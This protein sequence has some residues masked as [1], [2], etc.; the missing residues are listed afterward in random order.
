VAIINGNDAANLLM[1]SNLP[2]QINGLNGDDTLYGYAGVDTLTGGA[3]SD[4]LFG[5]AGNDVYKFGYGVGNDTIMGDAANISDTVLFGT[6]ITIANLT[7]TPNGS[8]LIVGVKDANGIA[9]DTM[10]IEGWF[11]DANNQIGKFKFANGSIYG[12]RQGDDSPNNIVGATGKDILYGY[13]GNDTLK[14]DA[15]DDV[16]YGGDGDD[17]V[18]GG[19]GLDKLYSGEGNDTLVYDATDLTVDGGT[20]FDLLDVTASQTAVQIDL[21]LNKYAEIEGM[22]GG[23][24]SDKLIGENNANLLSGGI[25]NDTLKGNGGNDTLL[26]GTGNDSMDGGVGDDFLAGGTGADKYLFGLGSGHDTVSANLENS[27]DTIVFGNGITQSMLDMTRKGNDLLVKINGEDSLTLI[28][29]F[30]DARNRIGTMSFADGSK[31]T[32]AG[33]DKLF[34]VQQLAG[35]TDQNDSVSGSSGDDIGTAGSGMDTVYGLDGSDIIYGGFGDDVLLGGIGDDVLLGGDLRSENGGNKYGLL[36]GISDYKAIWATEYPYAINDIDD[37]AN[38]LL[39]N[40]E[41]AGSTISALTDSSA[42]KANIINRINKLAQTVKPGDQVFIWFS[43]EISNGSNVDGPDQPYLLPYDMA[44]YESDPYWARWYLNPNTL[45][46]IGELR[47]ALDVVAN[48][49]GNGH[50]IMGLDANAAELFTSYFAGDSR[51]MVFA[52]SRWDKSDY[53]NGSFS[54]FFSQIG[55]GMGEG[56]LNGDGRITAAEMASSVSD[57]VNKDCYGNITPKAEFF[58]NGDFAIATYDGNDYLDGGDGNDILDG[59]AGEDTLVGGDGN[60]TYIY[61]K[62]YSYDVL[63]NFGFAQDYDN[64]KFAGGITPEQLD[65]RRWGNDLHIFVGDVWEGNSLV[66]SDWFVG[67]DHQVEVFYFEDGTIWSSNDVTIKAAA[68]SSIISGTSAGG[69]LI[70]GTSGNDYI[71][72][73]AGDGDLLR[74]GLG[75]DVYFWGTG[76]GDDDIRS[77]EYDVSTGAVLDHGYD[78]IMVSALA[79][80]CTWSHPWGTND[81]WLWNNTNAQNSEILAIWDW[82]K[83]PDYQPDMIRFIDGTVFTAQDI[84]KLGLG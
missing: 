3:G 50:I 42:T 16:L 23:S 28:G 44:S 38:A 2:D 69:E 14:G 53:Q 64:I 84:V 15:G 61:G 72:A 74:G 82:F 58:S 19:T 45:L 35:A 26:G 83:S 46:S 77:F 68:N 67:E 18:N 60:D 73:G 79:G 25:G 22:L 57:N 30:T 48:K 55:V 8:D 29:W 71:L 32:A 36:I 62:N 81:L 78:V 7:F 65:L 56:D 9:N 54:Y 17:L 4:L 21:N 5:G 66:I 13:G 39:G 12:Y 49:I 1:G 34:V 43:G 47:D 76:D 6:G 31:Q 52:S 20:G 51:Y 75:N 80:N 41:W 40:Q 10:T 70:I 37:V 27:T 59:G 63:D 33:I 11:T 24:G